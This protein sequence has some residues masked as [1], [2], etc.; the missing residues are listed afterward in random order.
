MVA[1]VLVNLRGAKDVVVWERLIVAVKLLVLVAGIF[2]LKPALLSPSL[3]PPTQ[4]IFFSLAITFFAYEGF[5][6]I[7]VDKHRWLDLSGQGLPPCKVHQASLGAL[8]LC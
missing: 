4:D 7:F 6:V 8:T 3:Y 2:Y 1:F 5:R